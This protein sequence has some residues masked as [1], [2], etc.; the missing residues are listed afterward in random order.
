MAD[1]KHYGDYDNL[2]ELLTSITQGIIDKINENI[3]ISSPPYA[4]KF[5]DGIIKKELFIELNKLIKSPK[6]FETLG[7]KD[8]DLLVY[9]KTNNRYETFNM[10]NYKLLTK[11]E[12][13]HILNRLKNL[14]DKI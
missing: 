12:Y 11:N 8:G 7:A 5:R 10:D 1:E 14:E 2:E 6:F 3:V 4:S 9:N 13:N